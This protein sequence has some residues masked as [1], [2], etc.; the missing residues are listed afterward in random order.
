MRVVVQRALNASCTVD[1]IITGQID[2]GFL[3]LVGFNN[4][5]KIEDLEY[6]AR[7]VAKLRVFEDE[8]GKMNKALEDVN[9]SIL[10]ISQFTLY[11]DTV[12]GNR[13]S[14]TNSANASVAKPLYERFNEILRNEYNLHVECGI[15]QADMKINFTND[16]PVT[17]VIDSNQRL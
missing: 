4:D 12:K 9:G 3:L 7:K 11:A 6:I 2:K 10:S 13:P 14:F 5:D 17:I 15:F 1:G 16:G 8:A